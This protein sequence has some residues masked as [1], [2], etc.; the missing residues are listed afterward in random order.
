M[1]QHAAVVILAGGSGTR[2]G[3][4][5]SKVYRPL[6]GRPVLQ[7]SLD[8]FAPLVG[9]LVVVARPDDANLLDPIV[10]GYDVSVAEGGLTRTG[11]ERAGLETLRSRIESGEV[12]LVAIHDGA[13]PFVTAALTGELIDTARRVGGA[14]P[15]WPTADRPDAADGS[16]GYELPG[17]GHVTVQ[18]PQ[19]FRAGELLA[20]Y[21]A[22]PE[23]EAADTALVVQRHGG[24]RIV[25]VASDPA[26]RKVTFPGDLG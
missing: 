24:V 13:R 3:G 17:F 10:A 14:V 25:L 12:D 8:T 11:S 1:D 7:W 9:H 19:V 18:T 23:Y 26:N 21:D 2:F 5:V 15:G 20:A 16:A 4:P 6:D 22:L